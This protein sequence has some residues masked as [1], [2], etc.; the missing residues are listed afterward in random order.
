LQ[1]VD[2]GDLGDVQVFAAFLLVGLEEGGLIFRLP[3]RKYDFI[4][5]SH[6]ANS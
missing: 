5:F 2:D 6:R 4:S 1:A 3:V